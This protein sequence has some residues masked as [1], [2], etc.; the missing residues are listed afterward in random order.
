[1]YIGIVGNRNR[2]FQYAYESLKGVSTSRTMLAESGKPTN[3]LF[4]LPP[5]WSLALEPQIT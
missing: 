1:M 3:V 4:L 5:N 2:R